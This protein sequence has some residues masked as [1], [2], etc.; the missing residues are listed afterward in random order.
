MLQLILNTKRLHKYH[1]RKEKAGEKEV[2]YVMR[3]R[4]KVEKI[5]RSVKQ[6]AEGLPGRR[7]GSIWSKG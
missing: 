2:K 4:Q 5:C 1:R 6:N 3:K 7:E